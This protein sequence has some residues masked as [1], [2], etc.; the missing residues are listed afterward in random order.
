MGHRDGSDAARDNP[1]D[2]VSQAQAQPRCH[3]QSSIVGNRLSRIPLFDFFFH[4]NI[5]FHV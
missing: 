2:H 4:T 3:G 1:S 5:F